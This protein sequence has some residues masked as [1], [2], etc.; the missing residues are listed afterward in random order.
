MNVPRFP[1]FFARIVQ[2]FVCFSLACF[3]LSLPVLAA[4][5]DEWRPVDPADLALKAPVVEKDADAEALFWDVSVADEADGGTP[6][7]VLNHYIRIK[8]FTERGRES[9]SKIDIVFFGDAKIKDIAAR[10]IKPD[11]SIV[12]LKKDDV[13]ERT[14][15]RL[16]GLKA[17]AK[18]FAMPGVEPGAIIEYRWR[19]VR[20]DHLTSYERLQFQR[21]IPIQLV[22]YHIKPLS[23][24]GFDYG[25]RLQTFHGQTSPIEKEKNG[26]YGI[27]M[28][29]VPAFHEEPRMPP[30]EQVRPWMLV[31]Y[32]QE[33]KLS[34]DKY[35]K[36]FGKG[37]YADYKSVMKPNDDVRKAS[38]EIIG[39]A[40]TPDEKLARLFEFCRTKIK[41]INASA[42]FG[43]SREAREDAKANKSVAD[44]LRRGMGTSKDIDLLFASLVIAA[45]F[46]ARVARLANR[47]DIF[48]YPEMFTDSYFLSTYDIAVRVAEEWRFFDPSSTYVPYGMLLW[49]E[50]GQQALISDPKDP[51]FVKTPLSLPQKSLEKRTAKLHLS[52]DGTLE[53][54]VRIEYTGHS[55][56][57]KKYFN[58]DDSLPQREENLRDQV[59]ARMSTAE[60]TDIHIEN[61]TDPVKPFVYAYHVRVPGYAQRTGKRLFLQPAF[62]Q[63]GAAA[64]FPTSDRRHDIYFHYPWAEQDI[65]EIE[66]P[67]GFALD[68]ADSPQPFTAANIGKYEVKLGTTKDDRTLIYR[69]NFFFG[70]NESI[71]FPATSYAQLKKIFDILHQQDDHTIT[72]KQSATTAAN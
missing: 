26:F 1:C 16:S 32:T 9:Q 3:I 41:N 36:E 59:K 23:L 71:L 43:L 6:R 31:Y 25:M 48:F 22:R 10:T 39:T 62:F 24:P 17:K 57:D 20:G 5:R 14:I 21:D 56:V 19:E 29:K 42:A 52:D 68:N 44:T 46:D 66:L 8:V 4:S 13:F 12:E 60:L 54:D 18:S 45:G 2:I 69:R 40:A 34:P 37:L 65:V 64:L 55:A 49:Q 47:N 15:V 30:E 11:G 27:Q 7:T 58:D 63:R 33:S 70:G 50:E 53:G 28:T 38:A 61:V 35:W 51:V 72:L 67:K